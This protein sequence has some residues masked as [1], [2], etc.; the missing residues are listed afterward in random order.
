[1][2]LHSKYGVNPTIPT[3]FWCGEGKDEIVFVGAEGNKIFPERGGEAPMRGPVMDYE[4]CTKCAEN[5]AKGA[6]MIEVTETSSDGRPPIGKDE[7]GRPAYP[8]GRF[9]VVTAEGVRHII[10]PPELAEGIIKRGAALVPTEAFELILPPNEEEKK[11]Q[12]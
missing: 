7:G 6:H 3:C 9:A 4:P 2:R 5:I 1:M 12:A 11:A 10:N 8:T